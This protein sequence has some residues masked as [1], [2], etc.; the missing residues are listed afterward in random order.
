[1]VYAAGTYE[2]RARFCALLFGG[3]GTVQFGIYT[4]K[5]QSRLSQSVAPPRK[6]PF[7]RPIC[8][9]IMGFFML[10]SFLGRGRLSSMMGI[11]AG[12]YLLLLPSYLLG[13][14]FYNVFVRPW[15][16][17]RWERRW[18]CLRC[19]AVVDDAS[20]AR[21]WRRAELVRHGPR[22]WD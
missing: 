4:A 13:S 12:F 21:P 15:K 9:W 3:A 22:L 1:M 20:H 7:L 10:M 6:L 16:Y 11:L 18:L 19:G 14:L 5:R 17:R 8:L 2:F